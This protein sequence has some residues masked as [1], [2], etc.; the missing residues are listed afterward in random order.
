MVKD[1]DNRKVTISD[2][3][4]DGE[5]EIPAGAE[6]V[7][8]FAHGSGSNRHS[9]RNQYVVQV[10]NGAGFATLLV[11]LLTEE[12]KKIDEKTRHLRFDIELLAS[13]LLAV[14]DWVIKQP[15]TS[16]LKIGY[17]ASSTGAA[18]ALISAA[19]LDNAVK[20]IVC[21]GG[22]P[23]LTESRKVLSSIRAPVLLIVGGKDIPV[24]G[25]NKF[26]MSQLSSAEAKELVIIP[27]ASHLFEESGKM[28]EV[29]Q[30]AAEWF[31]CCLSRNGKKKFNNKYTNS[32]APRLLSL[33]K[34][35]PRIQIR[36][37]DRVAAGE[38]L[39]SLLRNCRGNKDIIVIG[40][41]RGGVAVAAA[42]A[43][44]LD[45]KDFDIVIPRKLRAP[46]NSE[47]AIGAVMHDGSVY[48]DDK[49]IQSKKISN[50]Y[51]ELEKSEQRKEIDRRMN[52]YR[53]V[54]RNYDLNNRIVILVDDGAA[55]GATG[56]AAA[57]WIRKQQP[58]KIVIAFPVASSVAIEK[59][60]QESDELEVLISP[61]NFKSVERFYQDFSPMSDS[62]VIEIMRDIATSHMNL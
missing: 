2:E 3:K 54:R 61:S 23:D 20:A 43:R 8:L 56:A 30:V 10:L 14:T 53:P 27:N 1:Q 32:N 16:G 47:N 4:L 59:L 22:R 35:K 42:V 6:A 24:V 50:D 11:D 31:E 21:R 46:D 25:I 29:A 5:L 41:P 40:I 17:F 48:L 26:A 45:V 15:K 58:K 13:R 34:D 60:K 39:S 19:K 7:I 12:E 51:L 28:E 49:I 36:F 37:K 62:Q 52:L 33:F 18:A 44:K 57:R 38:M 9:T 55:S